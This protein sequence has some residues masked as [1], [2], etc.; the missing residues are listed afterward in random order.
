MGLDDIAG[1]FKLALPWPVMAV[2][3]AAVLYWTKGI[4]SRLLVRKQD[5]EER[6]YEDSQ[7][8]QRKDALVTVLEEQ[9]KELRATVSGLVA[10]L[11]EV[12]AAHAKCEI[13]HAELKGKMEV[14]DVK[15]S[16]LEAH[17]TA[18]KK[19]IESLQQS[20]GDA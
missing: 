19:N 4:P 5:M 9:V 1:L 7:D 17:D 14:M 16:R 15:L 10:E 6:Q 3:V 18:N 8:K 20:V 12:R 13:Q 11:K 2:I